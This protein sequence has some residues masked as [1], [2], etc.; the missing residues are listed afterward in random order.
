MPELFIYYR[1]DLTDSPAALRAVMRFQGDLRSR[2]PWLRTRLLQR[3]QADDG[4]ETW[5]ET[6]SADPAMNST[7]ITPEVAAQIEQAAAVLVPF[8]R[9]ARHTELFLACAS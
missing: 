8:L 3:P 2:H 1:L 9:G 7:G 6:Y 4:L 5:M